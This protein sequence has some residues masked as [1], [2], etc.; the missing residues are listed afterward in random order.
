MASPL[1]HMTPTALRVCE[2]E[3]NFPKLTAEQIA[4]QVG[5]NISTVNAYRRDP[6]YKAHREMLLKAKWADAVGIAQETMIEAA[7]KGNVKAAQFLL[8]TCGYAVET[9]AK[10]DATAAVD[11]N[12]HIEVKK[13]DGN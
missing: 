5:V 2:H 7:R 10:V 3:V 4:D 12:I 11:N 13:E 8:S 1:K 9:K 6:I